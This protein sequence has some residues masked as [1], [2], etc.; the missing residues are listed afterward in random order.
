MLLKGVPHFSE[1]IS[2]SA[3]LSTMHGCIIPSKHIE[4]HLGTMYWSTQAAT[5]SNPEKEI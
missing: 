5:D 2:T 3:R 1:S 4:T